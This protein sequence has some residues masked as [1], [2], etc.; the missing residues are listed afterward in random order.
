[1]RYMSV[2]FDIPGGGTLASLPDRCPIDP[3]I[4]CTPLIQDQNGYV[5]LI[6]GT[7]AAQPSWVTAANGYTWLDLTK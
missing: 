1:M 5:T 7:G 2:S 4:S 6:V 3:V